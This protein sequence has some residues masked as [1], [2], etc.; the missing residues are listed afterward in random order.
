L[1]GDAR[2]DQILGGAEMALLD[3]VSCGLP[4]PR[5]CA[6]VDVRCANPS[7]PLASLSADRVA[8]WREG[9]TRRRH[10]FGEF[11]EHGDRCAGMDALGVGWKSVPASSFETAS[12]ASAYLAIRRS[13]CDQ[14]VTG[15]T[16][17]SVFRRAHVGPVRT[18]R[19]C[20]DLAVHGGGRA[21]Q[22]SRRR[23]TRRGR[24]AGTLTESTL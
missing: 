19:P 8:R 3:L 23:Q 9:A 20:N 24:I 11:S 14:G 18:G 5:S 12:S 15:V 22:Q 4:A 13:T 16:A 17:R 10:N 2:A 1:D 6:W 21:G 7:N